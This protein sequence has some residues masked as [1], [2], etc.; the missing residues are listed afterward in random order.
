MEQR[1][2]VPKKRRLIDGFL[3][4]NSSLFIYAVFR[5]ASFTLSLLF[6][7]AV[8]LNLGW[9]LF[10]FFVVTPFTQVQIVDN[11]L[12]GRTPSLKQVN[13]PLKEVHQVKTLSPLPGLKRKFFKDIWSV[14]GQRMRIHRKFLGESQINA[15]MLAIEKYPFQEGAQ[16]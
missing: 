8:I 15:I 3:L 13:I 14:E 4:I 7:P 12:I 2:F 6:W 1:K 9:I 10:W 11:I 16:S 5:H